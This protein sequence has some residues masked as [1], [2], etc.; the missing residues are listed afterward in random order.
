[1][2]GMKIRI[3]RSAG[4][5]FGVQRAMEIA[6][7]AAGKEANVFMLGD[8]V[9]NEFVVEQ[10]KKAGIRV[11][12]SIDE[13]PGGV[14]LLRAHGTVPEVYAEAERRGLRVVDATCPMV[15]EIHRIVRSLAD[16]GYQV[17]IIGDHNHDEVRGIAGQVG[18]A[19]VVSVPADVEAWKRK[20]PR[21]GVVVQSTQSME[22]VQR[23][24]PCL[25][26]Y[27]REL[28][29][30]NTICKP[31][32]DHQSEI[33]RMP[34]DNDLMIVVGSYTSANTRRLT[35]LSTAINPRTRQVQSAEELQADWFEGVETVGISAGASTPD[36]LIQEVIAAIQRFRPDARV[37]EEA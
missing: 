25:L 12:N 4:F 19:L 20:Y 2:A 31:T 1:M 18:D 10:I 37:E 34:Q 32:T 28:R 15:L 3:A 5:C 13:I 8:I 7:E 23:I 14:L 17:V 21:L 11:V 22:N 35:E 30:I 27:C 9:H 33:C 26:R 6:L 29:F 16:E 24:L 36:I